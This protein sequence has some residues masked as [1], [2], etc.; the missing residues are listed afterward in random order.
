MAARGSA[1]T[2]PR[3]LPGSVLPVL[4]AA[5]QCGPSLE[6]SLTLLVTPSLLPSKIRVHV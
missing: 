4:P 3:P 5:G 2:A 1:C 6:M